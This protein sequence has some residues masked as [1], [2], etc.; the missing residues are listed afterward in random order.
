MMQA[1]IRGR[2]GK[3]AIYIAETC[4]LADQMQ[5]KPS[6]IALW[7]IRDRILMLAYYHAKAEIENPPNS[8]S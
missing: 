4:L 2:G 1:G 6:E 7:G 5:R 8:P 3:A